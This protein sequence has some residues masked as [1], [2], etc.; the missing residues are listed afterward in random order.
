MNLNPDIFDLEN[1]RVREVETLWCLGVI[2]SIGD[3]ALAK[4]WADSRTGYALVPQR[5]GIIYS[6][7]KADYLKDGM[8]RLQIGNQERLVHEKK[9]LEV[10]EK[11]LRIHKIT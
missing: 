8:M 4:A 3:F 6:A 2:L 9:Y 11:L 10:L 5:E 1:Y 7:I